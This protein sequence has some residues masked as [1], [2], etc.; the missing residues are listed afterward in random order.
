MLNV[1][2]KTDVQQEHN[3]FMHQYL[4]LSVSGLVTE[5]KHSINL[6][7][8]LS[9]VIIYMYIDGNFECFVISIIIRLGNWIECA[10][11]ENTNH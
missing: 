7:Y 1:L 6:H 3:Y 5:C 11:Y 9:S 2:K 4:I 10:I 8:N